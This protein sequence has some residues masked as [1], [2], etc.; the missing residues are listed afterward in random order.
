MAAL[1]ALR[2]G[3][4]VIGV[5]LFTPGA[6]PEL[7]AAT[8]RE[9]GIEFRP[10]DARERFEQCVVRE[11]VDDWARGLTPNPCIDC[12]PRVKFELLAREA[13]ALGAASIVTG[14]YAHIRRCGNELHLLRAIEASRDQ[15]YVLHRLAQPVLGRLSLPVG[16]IGKDEVRRL[17]ADAGLSAAERGA[18]Q[19]MCFTPDIAALIGERRP[20]ALRPGPI[21]DTQGRE[22]GRHRG[23]ARYTV[24]QR[25]G[26]GIGGPGGRAFVLRI[27]AERNTLV[28]GA[29]EDLWVERT[30][31]E[32]VHTI[33]DVPAERFEASVM[34]R[35]RG[36]ETPATVEREGDRATVHFHRPHRAPA[37]GQSAVFYGAQR[38]L[39]GGVIVP[40]G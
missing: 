39:G 25:R 36:A 15:S 31:I 4:K 40:G 21:V 23:L 34:T 11:F 38:C 14:H 26:L 32:R 29:E 9:L 37:P 17:A 2:A 1:L 6:R 5:T 19:D 10:I 13:D 24:G 18:S 30:Q 28:V 7:A 33:G 3:M 35:Y 27:D 12:N 20:E 16:E 22:I 8:C